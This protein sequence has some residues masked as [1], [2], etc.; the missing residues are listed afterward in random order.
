MLVLGAA[1]KRKKTYLFPIPSFVLG[2]KYP[3]LMSSI[4]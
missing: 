2:A 1:A 4:R 3:M